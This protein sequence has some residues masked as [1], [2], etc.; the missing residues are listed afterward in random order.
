M[1]FVSSAWGSIKIE[2]SISRLPSSPHDQLGNMSSR[3]TNCRCNK[4]ISP[5][6]RKHASTIIKPSRD[7]ENFFSF[8][9]RSYQRTVRCS[10]ESVWP[11]SDEC[12]WWSPPRPNSAAFF[13]LSIV[14]FPIRCHHPPMADFPYSE[15]ANS[16]EFR[17]NV[18]ISFHVLEGISHRVLSQIA[19]LAF[20][21][22]P[23]WKFARLDWK[24][25]VQKHKLSQLQP[26]PFT[27]NSFSSAVRFRP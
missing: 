25:N 17:L 23:L 9:L 15:P 1:P 4:N 26:C 18:N 22:E 13:R 10:H 14:R 3:S 6:S 24:L 11:P 12:C 7:V 2:F 27:I 19:H 20:F 5:K 16:F 8:Q 21:I